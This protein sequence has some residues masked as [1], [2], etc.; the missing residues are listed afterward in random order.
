M[1]ERLERRLGGLRLPTRARDAARA[2]PAVAAIAL[3]AIDPALRVSHP[4]FWTALWV[5][6][7]LLSWVGWGS[8]LAILLFPRRRLDWGLRA[9]LGMSTVLMFGGILG[10]VRCV[11][12]GTILALVVGGLIALGVDEVHFARIDAR[13]AMGFLRRATPATWLGLAF[14]WGC[15]TFRV[16]GSIADNG[17]NLWDDR[18]SYF[19]FPVQLLGS[20]T[21]DEP[22][23]I[24]RVLNLGGQPFLGAMVLVRGTVWN[25]HAVDGGLSYAVLFGLVLGQARLPSRPWTVATTVGLTLLLSLSLKIHNIGAELTG[26]VFFFALFRLFDTPPERDRPWASGVAVGIVAAA[27]C[28]L[29]QNFILAVGAIL[30]VHY[31]W[32]LIA[33]LVDRARVVREAVAA[34]GALFLALAAWLLFASR[35]SGTL[36]YPLFAGNTR[37]DF[38]L[39]DSVSRLEELRGFMDNVTFE[40]PAGVGLTFATIPFLLGKDRSARATQTVFVGSLLGGLGV[41]HALRSIDDR[42]SVGRY[43]F[44]FAFAYALGASMVATSLAS[45]GTRSSSR[46]F[47]AGAV[48]LAAIVAHLGAMHD[49][50][51]DLYEAEV[52]AIVARN[53]G[54]PADTHPGLDGLYA[55][56]QRSVPA[57]APLLVLLDE[58]FRL[59]FKR[60]RVMNLDQPGGVSPGRA[61]PIGQGED[62]L[63]DYLLAQGVRYIAFRIDGSSPEYSREKWLTHSRTPAPVV[64]NGY[65]RGTLLQSMS[66]FYLDVFDNLGRLSTTRRKLFARDNYFVLDLHDRG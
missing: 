1:T 37:P 40:A 60:N 58:P 6:L 31:L 33:P 43:Y 14:A 24:H 42:E 7:I 62:A 28:T 32:S 12:S 9:A 39:L 47:A 65:S 10:A 20:G 55:E 16:F 38:G 35:S 34:A 30:A 8:A 25:L 66:R 22:F 11:S 61:L 59:D 19:E 27:A 64:R 52:A 3:V 48:A 46:Y 21:L 17:A 51:R 5:A 53:D 56:I 63:A 45:R 50:I 36:L 29:R 57:G 18:I 13:R 4:L 15:L 41:I 54:V 2:A 49:G 44:A 23:S 26:A